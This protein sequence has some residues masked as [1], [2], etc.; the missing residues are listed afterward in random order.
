MTQPH[1]A[2][3][4]APPAGCPAHE[5]AAALYGPQFRR[6]PAEVYR[7]LRRQYG[8]VAPI[9]LEGDV[10][11]WFV[12]GYRELRQVLG[13]AQLFGRDPRRWNAWDRVPSDW[14]LLPVVSYVPLFTEGAEHQRHA[15]PIGDALTGIDQFELRSHCEVIADRLIDGFAGSGEAELMSQYAH[16][17][18]LLALA[19]ISGLPDSETPDLLRDMNATM[20]GGRGAMEAQGRLLARMQRLL[21]SKRE[22]PGPDLV[23]RMLAHPAKLTDEELIQDIIV[24]ITAGQQPTADWIGN[25]LRLML[26]DDR[27]ALTLSGGRRSA[28]QALNEVLWEDTPSQNHLG[29][30]AVRDTQLG[31]QRIQAGDLIVLGFAAANS[32]PQVRPDSYAGSVGNHAQMSFSHGEHQCPYPAPELAEVIAKAAVEVLLDRLPDVLLAVPADELEWRESV[33]LR[34]L[35]A[36]PVTFTP[37]YVTGGAG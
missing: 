1:H 35:S 26:T 4:P 15:Q 28:G 27:F 33:L 20:D 22:R 21:D 17:I 24:V 13:N 6:N 3:D 8:P 34:G 31:G 19:K 9:V 10:P 36:L 14:G 7:E 30:W 5:G 32:D 18:P 2:P 12:I 16:A 29:R 23:S 37:A 25:T 11:G